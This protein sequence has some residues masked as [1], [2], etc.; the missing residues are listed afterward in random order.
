M[1]TAEEMLA[2]LQ[3]GNRLIVDSSVNQVIRAMHGRN[4]QGKAFTCYRTVDVETGVEK[5]RTLI[6]GS[7]A[8]GPR[9]SSPPK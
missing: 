8:R 4:I 6:E 2:L 1:I 3:P 7:L 9:T 5:D